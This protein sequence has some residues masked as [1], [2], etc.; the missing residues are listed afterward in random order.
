MFATHSK[1]EA[2]NYARIQD[3]HTPKV[4]LVCI[5]KPIAAGFIKLSAVYGDDVDEREWIAEGNVKPA[6]LNRIEIFSAECPR[7]L[8][9]NI[10][11]LEVL[12]LVS[13]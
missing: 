11:P 13:K 2:H 12:F 1:K 5:E 6:F 10:E 3:W 4:A 8:T 9:L 7:S